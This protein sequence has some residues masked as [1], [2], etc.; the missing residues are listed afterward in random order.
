MILLLDLLDLEVPLFLSIIN[1]IN[2]INLPLQLP[3]PLPILN[4]EY[5]LLLV[6]H[7]KQSIALPRHSSLLARFLAKNA[8]HQHLARHRPLDIF[9]ILMLIIGDFLPHMFTVHI[10][11][12]SGSLNQ[13]TLLH[14]IGLEVIYIVVPELRQGALSELV[15]LL[16]YLLDRHWFL[17]LCVLALQD[18]PD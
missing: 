15:Y 8:L 2:G 16:H 6:S 12:L 9:G 11:M 3:H 7:T 17:L 10:S 18:E 5:R 13:L 4:H 14:I 1:A